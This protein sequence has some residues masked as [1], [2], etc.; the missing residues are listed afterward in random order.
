MNTRKLLHRTFC[1]MLIA[2]SL[3]GYSRIGAQPRSGDWIASTGFGEFTFTV[4]SNSTH[5]NKLSLTFASFTCGNI[6]RSGTITTSASPGWPITD[7]QFNIEQ[8]DGNTTTTINGTFTQTG[9]QASGTWS[10]NISGTICSGSW[11]PIVV[12]VEELGGRIPERFVLAQNYPNPF[13]PSTTIQFALSRRIHVS[14]KVYNA[15]GLEVVSLVDGHLPPGQ[16]QT[17]W[18]AADFASGVYLYRI[19]AG[20]F[21]ETKKLIFFK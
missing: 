4:D 12:S 14:I 10:F 6:T 18:N 19:Q 11:G 8:T 17:T 3:G 7:N 2:L 16:Y 13:N 1:V 20:D 15:L 9:D 21:V 5:I